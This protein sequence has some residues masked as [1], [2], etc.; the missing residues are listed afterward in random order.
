MRLDKL[1]G[2]SGTP[3]TY[4]L[5]SE[6]IKHVASVVDAAERSQA[7]TYNADFDALSAATGASGA[8]T[9]TVSHPVKG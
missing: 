1:W 4:T 7:T 6:G 9:E 3:D 5:T 2:T 8:A